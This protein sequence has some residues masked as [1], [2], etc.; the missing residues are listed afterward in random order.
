[1]IFIPLPDTDHR[2]PYDGLIRI[3]VW[4]SICNGA[5]LYGS[6]LVVGGAHGGGTGYMVICL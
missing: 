2:T 5:I 4:L 1:M 6:W 3:L